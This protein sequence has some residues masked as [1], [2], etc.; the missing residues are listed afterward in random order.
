MYKEQSI[1]VHVIVLS[2]LELILIPKLNVI[3]KN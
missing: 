1:Q 2:E 3:P